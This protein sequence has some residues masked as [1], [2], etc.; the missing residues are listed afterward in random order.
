MV[1]GL[2]ADRPGGQPLPV[3]HATI[4][5]LCHSHDLLVLDNA[6][7]L[8]SAPE[9]SAGWEQHALDI[10]IPTLIRHH[11]PAWQGIPLRPVAG[12]IVPL[13]HVRHLRVLINRHTY[14]EFVSRWPKLS[15]VD[16][17][18]VVYNRVDVDALVGGDRAG[19]RASLGVRSGE[20]LIAG[21]THQVAHSN[22]GGTSRL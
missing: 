16:A 20:I 18:R 19:T 9:A 8:W 13:H 2:W 5:S 17:L 1:D 7:S 3:D 11:D 10:G 4:R 12:D 6:G 14:D 22:Q 21:S 15:D